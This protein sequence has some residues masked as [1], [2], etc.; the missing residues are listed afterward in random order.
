M[1]GRWFGD[2]CYDTGPP[3]PG[4]GTLG[5][6][7]EGIEILLVQS[8][9]GAQG[10]P[11]AD[12]GIEFSLGLVDA[13]DEY[14]FRFVGTVPEG[15]SLGE[16]WVEVRFDVD[17]LPYDMTDRPFLVIGGLVEG[18]DTNEAAKP[19]APPEPAPHTTTTIASAEPSPPGTVQLTSSSSEESGTNGPDANWW[20]VLG[21]IGALAIGL[22]SV[23]L[24]VDRRRSA[25]LT[26]G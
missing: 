10:R 18:V 9:G 15:V 19:V 4:E 25:H 1:I 20:I 17:W 5:V 16:A 13:D 2:N 23:T 14:R 21:A 11:A 7:V 3:P 12:A 24:V 22:G 8:E 26:S 6:P